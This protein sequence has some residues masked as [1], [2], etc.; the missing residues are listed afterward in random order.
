MKQDDSVSSVNYENYLMDEDLKSD[1]PFPSRYDVQRFDVYGLENAFDRI[2][3]QLDEAGL[4]DPSQAVPDQNRY[5]VREDIYAGYAMNTWTPSWGSVLAGIRLEHAGYTSKGFRVTADGAQPVETSTDDTQL[6]PSLHVN[7]DLTN[8]LRLRTAATRTISRAGFAE[9]RPSVSID[10]A[11]QTISGGNPTVDAETAW[12]ADLSLEY[13]LPTTGIVSVSAFSKWIGNPLFS[14]S[15]VVDGDRFDTDGFDRTGYM[16][17][18]TLNGRD[19]EVYGVELNYFQQW[20]FLPGPLAGFGMQANA[21]VLDSEFTTPASPTAEA[22]AVRFPGTSDTVFNGSL[23]FERYGVSARVSY[24]WRD[25]WIDS[26]DPTD[27]RL[28]TYWDADARLSAS[29]RYAFSD[30][31]TLFADANNLTDELGRR[32]QGVQDKPLE[33]EGFGRRYQLGVRVNY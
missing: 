20:H 16:Y 9:R 28:D 6:F 31:Y 25:D 33:V 19:G 23:F 12:S 2:V 5:T 8:N 27:Q 18:T 32:Y 21:T 13:Y 3:G 11:S 22:R 26:L 7:V 30:H 4:Y 1:F 17:S 15:T 14:S 29:V 24:Q 10:D